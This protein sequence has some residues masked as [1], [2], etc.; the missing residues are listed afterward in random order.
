MGA[1]VAPGD[2]PIGTPGPGR[3]GVSAVRNHTVFMKTFMF[4]EL[5]AQ[6]AGKISFVHI[7]P[8]LVDGPVFYSTVNPW[9]FRM[10]WPPM[11]L[12]LSWYMTSAEDCGQV[13]LYLATARYPAKGLVGDGG[14][15]GD[16]RAIA[17][18]TQQE[19]G[20][21]AYGVGQRGDALKVV[22]YAN[23]RK[24]STAKE[25]WDHTTGIL[26]KIEKKN[27]GI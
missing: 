10:L 14:E 7:Y 20:G 3:Y 4:E 25:I 23:V 19:L 13:M 22:S 26:L 5:A 9:W 15:H 11:K 21:G 2:L 1:S 16:V 12:L 24:Y 6:H 18:S 17:C 27:A 8:G